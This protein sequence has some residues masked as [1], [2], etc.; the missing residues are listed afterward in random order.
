[1]EKLINKI[2]ENGYWKIIIRP[3]DYK[4]N[5]ISNKDEVAKIAENSKIVFR[6]WDY[7]HIDHHE[8][9]VRS[10]S[11]SVSSYCDWVEGGHLEFWKLYLNGQFIHYFSMREDFEI[12]DEYK[13]KV[14]QQVPSLNP[15]QKIN[16]LFSII[17][18]LYSITEIFFFASNLAKISKYGDETEIVIE[19]NNT[20]DRMLFFWDSS[21]RFL[22]QSY[23]CRYQPIKESIII[24]TDDLITNTAD[25]ALDFTINLFK[26]FN[27]KNANKN[28]FISDQTKLIEKRL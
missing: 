12:D 9:I 13:Q 11:D 19:L 6:G 5:R 2:K 20:K 28:V 26:E 3:V 24:R 23:I 21:G 18:A 14:I 1:M 8:G 27:W 17:N 15:D 7:P 22:S 4:E 10:G 25:L 16:G